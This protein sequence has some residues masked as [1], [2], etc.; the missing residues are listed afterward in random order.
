[1]DVQVNTLLAMVATIFLP[2]TFLCGVYGMNFNTHEGS[3]AIP[4]LSLG[5]GFG[6]YVAYWV[7][8]VVFIVYLLLVF[9][10]LGWFRLV[11]FGTAKSIKVVIWSVILAAAVIFGE[12]MLWFF[13]VDQVQDPPRRQAPG[14][15][16][17]FG[18]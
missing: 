13:N 15:Y 11:G 9:M 7:I 3:V 18:A 6:G 4:L 16:N 17:S 5:D 10:Q 12:A 8:C 14:G 1:M 2:L